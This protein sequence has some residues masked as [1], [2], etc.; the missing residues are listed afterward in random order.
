[1]RPPVVVHLIPAVGQGGA[2][3]LLSEIVQ[4]ADGRAEHHIL[5]M[6]DTPPFFSFA[7]APV[8]HLGLR[9][10]AMPLAAMPRLAGAL[11]RPQPTV[12]H[13]WL[14][15]GNLLA[16]L[17]PRRGAPLIW[18]IHNT[19]LP[20][21]SFSLT[22]AVNR[23]CA[24]QS[25]RVPWRIVYC[26]AEARRL[27]EAQ[28]YARRLGCVIE[29]GADFDAFAFDPARRDAQR[30]AW[31]LAPGTLA[32]GCAARF[33][34]QKDH[35]GLARAFAIL[36]EP[37]S[38]LLLAGEGCT[39]ANEAL[40]TGLRSAGIADRALLLGLL[41]DMPAFYAALD[42][43]VIGSAHGEALPMVG[44]EAAASGLPVAATRLGAAPELVLAPSHL[45]APGVPADLARAM[46]AALGAVAADRPGYPARAQIER[47]RWRHDILRVV[48]AYHALYAQAAERASGP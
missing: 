34:P 23:A 3:R 22:R 25:H 42:L 13:S 28:G 39:A 30:V 18:S 21:A 8:T 6:T 14:Y 15:H 16:A 11:Y 40:V 45:A 27:H 2:E 1:M 33:D 20:A 35:V 46:A 43:L 44:L 5:A 12:I 4:R 24:L 37:R 36:A 7:G 41:A 29:N 48:D 10:G 26:A 19:T 9:R 31:G 47:L 38:R 17:L 32:I